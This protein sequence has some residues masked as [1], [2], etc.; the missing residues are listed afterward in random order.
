M[1]TISIKLTIQPQETIRRFAVPSDST[2]ESFKQLITQYLPTDAEHHYQYLD[3]E[4]EWVSFSSEAEWKDALSHVE[5]NQVLRI[6]VATKDIPQEQAKCGE[7]SWKQ[8]HC[9]PKLAMF[10]VLVMSYPILALL[11]IIAVI[12]HAKQNPQSSIAAVAE[13]LKKHRKKLALLFIV[14]L[15]IHKPCLIIPIVILVLIKKAFRC[16]VKGRCLKSCRKEWCQKVENKE[17]TIT[18]AQEIA[19]V[20]YEDQ[21]QTL[22]ALGFKNQ[23]LNAHLLKTF[24]GDLG[25]VVNNLLKVKSMSNE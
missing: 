16:F 13:K 11:G 19:E 22:E 6:R 21:Q 14:R 8:R 1:S 5:A 18:S 3:E 10:L 17:Q 2:L 15:L 25:K 7:F 9:G 4:N 12:Y 24:K 20:E 23:K